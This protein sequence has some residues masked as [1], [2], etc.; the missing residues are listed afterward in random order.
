MTCSRA[1]SAG[2]SRPPVGAFAAPLPEAFTAGDGL[3]AAPSRAGC[4]LAGLAVGWAGAAGLRSVRATCAVPE[5]G[6]ARFGA[7]NFGISRVAVA[8]VPTAATATVV[9][10]PVPGAG[11]SDAGGAA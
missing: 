6:G 11:A 5:G 3:A 1:A 2:P 10:A 4:L 7:R 8:P 9:V